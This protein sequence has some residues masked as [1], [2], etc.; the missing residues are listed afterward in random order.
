[1]TDIQIIKYGDDNYPKRLT[2]LNNPPEK[3]YCMGD[4]SL[5]ENRMAAIVGSRKSSTYGKWAA[6][7]IAKALS[8]SGITVISG[9]AKGI[10]TAAHLGAIDGRGKTVAVLGCGIDMCYPA[11][12][13]NLKRDIAAYGLVISEYP[14]GTE[15]KRWTFPK[16]NRIIAGLSELVVV[17]EAGL[18]SGA[19]ITAELAAAG[20]GKV[21]AVPGNI[22]SPYS[23]GSNKLISDGVAPVVVIGDVLESMGIYEVDNGDN[24]LES[25]L[26][27]AE[28][29]VYMEIKFGGE[30]S[31]DEVCRRV[32]RAPGYV[33]GIIAVLEMKGLVR[34]SMG[35]VFVAK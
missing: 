21:M 15:A 5:L 35:K 14:P 6:E 8:G 29:E 31:V 10:D 33:N 23:I 13:R 26:G 18:N 9:M 12:N 32:K 24:N 4:I 1:M 19:L 16:R 2:E 25:V 20:Y 30:I 34:T 28:K 22:N 3:L 7:S 17:V 27:N 11:E